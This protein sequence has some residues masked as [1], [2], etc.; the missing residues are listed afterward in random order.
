ME[1]LQ[2]NLPIQT[3]CVTST[4][5][6]INPLWFRYE[7][8]AHSIIKV[9]ISQILACKEIKTAGSKSL[10]YTCEATLDDRLAIVELQYLI[11]SHKW[12]LKR[13]VA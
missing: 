8:D 4:M 5:G 13:K 11:S 10:V 9:T 3:L 2:C 1:I 6:D 7:D 12:I